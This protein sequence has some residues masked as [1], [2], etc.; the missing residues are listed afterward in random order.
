ME[1]RLLLTFKAIEE[2]S[3][4]LLDVTR[5]PDID[6]NWVHGDMHPRQLEI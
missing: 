1:L 6:V 5:F 2:S 4:E 3:L